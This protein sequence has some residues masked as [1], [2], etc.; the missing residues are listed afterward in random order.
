[1][2]LIGGVINVPGD[3]SQI[4]HAFPCDIKETDIIAVPIKKR[5]SYKSAYTFGRI[6]VHIVMRSL[7]RL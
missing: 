7:R 4:Q 6:C 5:L 1:M 3:M 2:G